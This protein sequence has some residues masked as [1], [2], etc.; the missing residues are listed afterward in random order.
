MRDYYQSHKEEFKIRDKERYQ[1]NKDQIKQRVRD[2]RAS[3]KDLVVQRERTKFYRKY[4]PGKTNQEALAAYNDLFAEQQGK[5]AICSIHQTQLKKS[6]AVD[7]C[8]KTGEVRGLLC[9]SCNTGIGQLKDSCDLLEKAIKYLK[10]KE[11]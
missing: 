1:Q 6:L 10:P 2:Y 11:N 8:H 7:H 9:S 4:W 5:C 3:N